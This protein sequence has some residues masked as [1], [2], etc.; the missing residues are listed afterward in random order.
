MSAVNRRSGGN[1][2]AG[3]AIALLTV[4]TQ[5]ILRREL[6]PGEFGTLNTLLGLA[7][8]LVVPLGAFSFV[9]RRALTAAQLEALH[10]P[11]LNRAALVWG[12]LCIILLFISLPFL[13]LPRSSLEYCML[14]TIGAALF[15][16]CGRPVTPA[17]WCAVIGIGAAVMR[18]IVSAWAAGNW[19]LAE[20]G[21]AAFAL[22]GLLAGLPALRDQPDTAPFSSAWPT[23][24]A[25]LVPGLATIS[26]ALALVLFTNADRVAAQLNLG[27]VDPDA[28][29]NMP[30]GNTNSLVNYRLFDDYQ[31][32]GLCMR[33]LLWSLLPL[34]GAFYA[35]RAALPRTTYAS[36]R[37]FW[38]YLGALLVGTIAIAFGANVVGFLFNPNFFAKAPYDQ[39]GTYIAG[40]LWSLVP[41]F[42]GPFL[43][44]GLLQGVAIFSLASRRHVE[45]FVLAA[46]SL[47]YT[48]VLFYVGHHAELLSAC[49]FGGALISLMVL[50]FTGVVRYARTHP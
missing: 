24:R 14:L 38:I 8:I 25:A 10:P 28:M 23:L 34:L 35:Q 7:L 36:L 42:A 30:G 39:N 27:T 5:I 49:M 37:F 47:A 41:S 2:I 9:L 46:C 50:L 26:V 33:G 40:Y 48:G 16:I 13:Q 1:L 12:I 17:K 4:L 45:C 32:A 15:A 44:L 20:S 11:L 3:G 19:T 21:L 29:V 18:L 6:A 22:A 43:A 31:A